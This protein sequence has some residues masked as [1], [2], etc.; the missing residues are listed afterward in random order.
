[1]GKP[2]TA[3]EKNKYRYFPEKNSKP[4][5]SAGGRAEG[6]LQSSEVLECHFSHINIMFQM[7]QETQNFILFKFR[8]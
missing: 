1:M 6:T 4:Q 2:S 3:L 5:S 8:A 7:S